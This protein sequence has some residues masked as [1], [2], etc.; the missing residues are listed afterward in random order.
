VSS[1]DRIYGCSAG[2]LSGCFTAA[3]QAMLWATSFED[4]TSR[5]CIDPVRLLRG[6]PVF[7]L[8]FLFETVID[9]RRPLLEAG[10][11]RGPAFYAVAASAQD[12]SL[13][14]LGDF[15][16]MDELL[17]ALRVSCTVPLLGGAPSCY[18]GEP[19]LDGGL[20]EPIPYRTALRQGSTH[21]LVLRSR[22]AQYRAGARH[23][24]TEL[25]FSRAHP[26][27]RAVLGAG[28]RYNRDAD[29]LEDY[30]H[31]GSTEPSVTQV[32]VPPASRLVRR[33]STDPGRIA[34]SLRL[35]AAAMASALYGK[36][37]RLM[38][39]PVAYLPLDARVAA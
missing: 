32:A 34:E 31:G 33:V 25:A 26:R 23:R 6:R 19:M 4:T 12:A 38:W 15:R 29:A 39:Q 36:P 9:G 21:V 37:A 28:A 16:D 35:G 3:G 22:D 8:D 18:R 7:D 10:M 5:E 2:A 17:A 14:V 1:F 13:R 30:T 20:I 24:V 27:L 11:P